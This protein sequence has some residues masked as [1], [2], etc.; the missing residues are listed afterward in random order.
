VPDVD[1]FWVLGVLEDRCD[2]GRHII[3]DEV[4]DGVIPVVLLFVVL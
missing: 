1:N 4:I 2:E 3:M